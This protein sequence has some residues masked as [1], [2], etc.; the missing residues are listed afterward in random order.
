MNNLELKIFPLGKLMANSYLVYDRQ[1]RKGFIVDLPSSC[2]TLIDY[3][4]E[5]GID[6]L[7]VALTHAHFDHIG[8]L[9]VVEKPFYVQ[10]EDRI[11]LTDPQLNGSALFADPVI[12]NRPSIL[13]PD[14]PLKFKDFDIE[15]IKT[16]GHTPGSVSL[17]I[18][19]W[20][21]TGDT[22]FYHSIGRTDIPL[23]ST[24]VILS[25]ITNNL[26]SLND[27]L[28]VYPGHG[29]STTIG[30]EKKENPFF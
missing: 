12:I 21:F 3:I 5:Q 20:L 17:K 27:N 4:N 13:Y 2:E 22:L 30:E 28:I 1:D 24:D 29:S 16:P 23:A 8:G 25:S 18:A 6:V 14:L 11:F 10:E 26:F 7:F 15:I 9:N 19:N